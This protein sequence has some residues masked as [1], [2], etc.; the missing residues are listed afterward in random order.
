M[1]NIAISENL[2]KKTGKETRDELERYS[3]PFTHKKRQPP[4][5]FVPKLDI[6]IDFKWLESGAENVPE[7]IVLNEQKRGVGHGEGPLKKEAKRA[8]TPKRRTKGV[9]ANLS[10]ENSSDSL[11]ELLL[12][13][14]NS[15]KSLLSSISPKKS[16]SKKEK[17]KLASHYD[18]LIQASDKNKE[19]EQKVKLVPDSKP[20]KPEP[21]EDP[22]QVKLVKDGVCENCK[23]D[24]RQPPE[25]IYDKI[26]ESLK[27]STEVQNR[28]KEACGIP[29]SPESPKP[30]AESPQKSNKSI[31]AKPK[32]CLGKTCSTPALIQKHSKVQS[33]CVKS[34]VR[35]KSFI[36]VQKVRRMSSPVLSRRECVPVKTLDVMEYQMKL[37]SKMEKSKK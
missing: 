9:T 33:D 25:N 20:P 26:A 15:F 31:F 4:T 2:R 30:L 18:S 32:E 24:D 35:Q 19:K 14:K 6:N 22:A 27:R 36:E 3:K 5:E 1:A 34:P 8:K 11:D 7:Y 10:R 16:T 29:K 37:K 17:E 28:I 12:M 13:K 23:A 21:N